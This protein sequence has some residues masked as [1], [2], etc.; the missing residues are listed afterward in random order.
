MN[1]QWDS[2]FSSLNQNDGVQGIM[3][4]SK[5][6]DVLYS[7]K[8]LKNMEIPYSLLNDLFV[9]NDENDMVAFSFDNQL[10]RIIDFSGD[11]VLAITSPIGK[12]I[13]LYIL[14][15]SFGYL[16]IEMEWNPRAN[17]C[18]ILTKAN[19]IIQNI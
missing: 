13:G 3:F 8:Q 14:L 5:R 9:L 1:L 2:F 16:I 11:K 15:T 7:T 6:N 12:Q 18:E 10:F 19:E 17:S 4:I